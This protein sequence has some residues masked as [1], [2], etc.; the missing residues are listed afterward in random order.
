MNMSP[1][2]RK[3]LAAKKKSKRVRLN[4]VRHISEYLSHVHWM[5]LKLLDMRDEAN[6]FIS[7]EMVVRR[8]M[9]HYRPGAEFDYF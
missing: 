8:N 4:R 9:K 3:A 2:K 5:A 6:K 1:R 7:Y